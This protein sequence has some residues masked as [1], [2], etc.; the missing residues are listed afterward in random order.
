MSLVIAVLKDPNGKLLTITQR[1]EFEKIFRSLSGDFTCTRA[2]TFIDRVYGMM[3]SPQRGEIKNNTGHNNGRP[4]SRDQCGSQPSG[5]RRLQKKKSHQVIIL[6]VRIFIILRQFLQRSVLKTRN[7]NVN[8]FTCVLFF[9]LQ[10]RVLRQ[11]FVDSVKL[12]CKRS[13]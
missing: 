11:K 9:I 1:T 2:N 8:N 7:H 10:V 6:C 12:K 5:H 3:V 4:P 13:S